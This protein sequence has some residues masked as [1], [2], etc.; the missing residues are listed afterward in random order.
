MAKSR[1]ETTALRRGLNLVSTVII[2]LLGGLLLDGRAAGRP[3]SED[4]FESMFRPAPRST[5]R[6]LSQAR[7]LI[8]EG[9]YGEA[10]RLLGEILDEPDDYF[11]RS[12]STGRSFRSLKSEAERMIGRMPRKGRELYE[13][14][15]GARAEKML[16]DALS[17]GDLSR[18][19]E[20]SRR[21][22]HTRGGYQATFLLGLHHFDHG[23]PLAGAS[24][25]RRLREVDP[26][27]EELEPDLSLTLASCWLKAGR[28]EKA[29][30]QLVDLRRRNPHLRVTAAGKEIPLFDDDS[31]AVDWLTGLIGPNTVA[32]SFVPENW[33]LF[34]GGASRN[35]ASDGGPPLLNLRWR[36]A[37]SDDPLVACVLTQYGSMF[38][39]NK[40]TAIPAFHPLAVDDYVLMRTLHT[41]QAVDF[42]T[43]KIL[44]DVPVDDPKDLSE[45]G[46]NPQ[47]AQIKILGV[48]NRM[49]SD[50]T[51]GTLSSD[52]RRVYSVED[53][54]S[55]FGDEA[56]AMR[57]IAIFGGIRGRNPRMGVDSLCNRLAAHDIR[58]GKLVWEIGGADEPQSLR[59]PGT[60]FLGPPLPLMDKL[61]ALAETDKGEVRLM[62]LNPTDGDLLWS[63]Q[64]SLVETPVLEAPN[65]RRMG[66]SPSYADGILVCP[67]S[68]GAVAGIELGTGSLLWGYCYISNDNNRRTQA[69]L[70]Q[71]GLTA[72]GWLD[73]GVTICDGRVLITPQDSQA[74][75]CLGLHDGELLWKTERKDDLYLAC[76]A[77]NKAVLVGLGSIRALRLEDGKP[78]WEGRAVALPGGSAPSGRGFLS[79]NRYFLPL[80]SA[81]VAAVDIAEGKIVRL[82][83]S[84]NG[85]IPGNLICHKNKI[86]SQGIEGVDLFLELELAS[87]EVDRRLKADPNDAWALSLRGEILLDA[88]RR[89]EAIA[90][91]RRAFEISSGPRTQELL[92][93]SL[94][95]GLRKEFAAYRD[96]CPEIEPLLEGVAQRATYLRLMASGFR[97]EGQMSDAFQKY[98]ELAELEGDENPL[99]RVD[100]G[101]IVR[102]DRWIQLQ[103]AELREKSAGKTAE[104]IDETVADRMK[105]ATKADSTASLRR[106]LELFGGLDAAQPAKKELLRRLQGEGK[107]LESELASPAAKKTTDR[108]T[109]GPKAAWPSGNVEVTTAQIKNPTGGRNNLRP[110]EF[111]GSPGPYFRDATIKYDPGSREIIAFD[112]AGKEKWKT[113]LVQEDKR[114]KPPSMNANVYAR[115]VGPLLLVSIGWDVYAI[116]TSNLTPSEFKPDEAATEISVG[117][118]QADLLWGLDMSYPVIATSGAEGDFPIRLPLTALP[119]Q[120]QQQF[121]HNQDQSHLLGACSR[122]YVCLQR[123]QNVIAVDPLDGEILW[124]RQDLPAAC[125]VF[126]DDEHLFVLSTDREEATLLRA[127]DGASLGGKKVPRQKYMQRLP[128]G[129]THSFYSDLRNTCLAVYGRKLLLWWPEGRH[130]ELTMID[131]LEGRDEWPRRKFSYNAKTFVIEDDAIGVLEPDGHFALIS[132]PDGRSIADVKLDAEPNLLNIAL[133]KSEDRYFL[134]VNHQGKSGHVPMS[135][136]ANFHRGSN[137][138]IYQGR[139]YAFDGEGKLLWPDPAMVESQ[140]LFDDQ[141]D[142]MPVIIFACR[143]YERQAN[144]RV[145][146]KSEIL[147]INKRD[148][149]KVYEEEFDAHVSLFNAACDVEKKTVVLT[150]DNRS[151]TLTF[152]DNPI[153]PPAKDAEPAKST[154]GS[155]LEHALW[156]SL[157]K[158]F[159][160][161]GA[162]PEEEEERID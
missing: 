80:S 152:T 116:D 31:E 160:P 48:S 140:Y 55:D 124:V 98:L 109:V 102:R 45:P 17:S 144:G 128:N 148:G 49:W 105:T 26:P 99:D 146:W 60:F 114:I 77:D 62:A 1:Y 36:G 57:Q 20:V 92:R 142:V 115:A 58:T 2:L 70:S 15:F 66:I 69:N 38:A 103:L 86:L 79:G 9:R 63:Q 157:R 141:F 29:R 135:P 18:L 123:M 40:L 100:E 149:R 121:L 47:Q 71:N 129:Q 145:S 14:Q 87:A 119:A 137:Y 101:L 28:P 138:P 93:D 44:W 136:I 68:T 50:L 56:E 94:L 5:L 88:G 11:Y 61:Y 10:V 153:P 76:A 84:Q 96:R 19:A 104:E 12:D 75:Y 122:R 132:L 85:N 46:N 133:F 110:A 7:L 21:F 81:E 139:L 97:G 34:R 13:L 126:G 154:P 39:K 65:R 23:R 27:V 54:G 83:K 159:V 74:I 51:Y 30:E 35:A 89:A 118:P 67:T 33:L 8:E 111:Q 73:N 6:T 130:R 82:S 161:G 4:D 112:D 90:S 113:S 125:D 155:K 158:T 52:G 59:Q 108:D 32:A 134:L 127:D 147:C 25:L 16:N 156:N 131:P 143:R 53:L 37:M 3:A 22:F 72:Q 151:V 106:F 150:V 120:L 42:A 117:T 43:G 107:L 78:A 91:F 24:I 162:L 95:E 41:L 64:L